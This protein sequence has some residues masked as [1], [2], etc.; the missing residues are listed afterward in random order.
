MK[1]KKKINEEGLKEIMKRSPLYRECTL[2]INKSI[3]I[4]RNKNRNTDLLKKYPLPYL[5]IKYQPLAFQ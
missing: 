4:N 3:E 1:S 2:Q 5:F